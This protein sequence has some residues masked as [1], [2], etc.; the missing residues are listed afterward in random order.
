MRI[1]ACKSNNGKPALWKNNDSRRSFSLATT[2]VGHECFWIS[3]CSRFHWVPFH[4]IPPSIEWYGEVPKK[5][6]SDKSQNLENQVVYNPLLFCNFNI[7]S[8]KQI[9]VYQL[10]FHFKLL[11]WIQIKACILSF[12]RKVK[13]IRCHFGYKTNIFLWN[14]LKK[15]IN[16]SRKKAWVSEL[17]QTPRMYFRKPTENLIINMQYTEHDI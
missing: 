17:I 3:Y 13:I 4:S 11:L 10:D 14:E 9:T 12:Q 2:K 16:P 1:Y 15:M 5:Y 7:D 6:G 8:P